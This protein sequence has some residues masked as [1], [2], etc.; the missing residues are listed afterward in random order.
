MAI[1]RV[2]GYLAGV[3]LV[4]AGGAISHFWG[5]DAAGLALITAGAAA[6]G[7]VTPRPGFAKDADK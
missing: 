2:L 7:W 3:A 5:A 4:V 1:G 6:G